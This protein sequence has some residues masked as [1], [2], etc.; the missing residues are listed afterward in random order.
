MPLSDFDFGG[1]VGYSATLSDSDLLS[2]ANPAVYTL[3]NQWYRYVA[4]I[5]GLQFCYVEFYQGATTVGFVPI[6]DTVFTMRYGGYIGSETIPSI[7][8]TVVSSLYRGYQ[9]VLNNGNVIVWQGPYREDIP[10]GTHIYPSLDDLFTTLYTITYRDTNA[11][12]SGPV[13]AA[14][15]DNIVVNY[16][17]PDGYGIV[18][19]SDIYVTNNGVV[20]PSTYADGTLRFTMPDPS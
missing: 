15:G 20:I 13:E 2:N 12:H 8:A 5:S 3:A 1:I 16:T 14:V 7:E 4:N 19:S 10:S 6:S 9:V 18:N 17:F 11:T